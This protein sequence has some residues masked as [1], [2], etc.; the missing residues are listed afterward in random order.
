M[1]GVGLLHGHDRQPVRAALGRQ[2]EVDDLGELPG[3]Q[4]HEHF[5]EGHAQH[6]RLVGRLAGVGGVVDGVPAVG[7]AIDGEDGEPVLLV[8]VAGVVAVGA[9][10]GHFIAGER[11]GRQRPL[12]AQAAGVGQGLLSVGVGVEVAFQHDLGGGGHVQFGVGHTDQFGAGAAQQAGELVFGQRV[13]HRGDGAQDGGRVGAQDGGHGEGGA[14]ELPAVLLEVQRATA[15]GQPAH[16]GLVAADDLLAV[17]AQVLARLAGAARHHQTPGDQRGGVARPAVLDGQGVQVHAV[18]GNLDLAAGAAGAHLGRHVHDLA[19]DGELLPGVL[20]AA[21][22]LGLL[23]VGQKAA[24]FTQGGHGILAHAQGHPLRGAE[25]VGE[26]REVPAP[27]FGLGVAEQQRRA[28]LAQH[29]IGYLGHFQ[30]GRDRHVDA[31]QLVAAFQV[32]QELPQVGIA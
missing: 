31:A 16:D 20:Q 23:Q 19:Q 5:V 32:L 10:Q 22:R 2:V 1:A 28:A 4:R 12:P 15:M 17:D 25:E 9:F 29:P 26:Y 27:A 8:V 11:G 6:G 21:R 13:G 7:D 14:G 18:G 24:H 30:D 3:E